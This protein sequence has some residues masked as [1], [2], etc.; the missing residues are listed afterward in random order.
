MLRRA[1]LWFLL[2]VSTV[3]GLWLRR[4]ALRLPGAPGD[5][6]GSAGAGEP[7]HLLAIGDSIIDGVGIARFEDSLPAQFARELSTQQGRKVVWRA[8]G[9]TG[10]SIADIL[11]RLE[12][13]DAGTRADLVLVSAGVNDVTALSSTRHWRQC[14]VVLLDGLSGRWPGARLIFLGLPPM[15]QFPLPP[16]PLRATLGM[17]AAT[18]D[19]IA[20]GVIAGYPGAMHVPTT[21]SPSDHSFCEDGFHPSAESCTLWARELAAIT[22]GGNSSD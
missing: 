14:L 18:L 15:E 12:S 20:A 1:A 13:L 8:E 11:E 7:L 9:R 4:S 10:Y 22:T 3:Q 16:Q 19:R 17:R 2:P 21:I 6:T 5:R